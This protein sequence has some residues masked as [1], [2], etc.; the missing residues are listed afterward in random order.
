[1]FNEGGVIFIDRLAVL[2]RFTCLKSNIFYLFTL[3]I[4][5]QAT[6]QLKQAF[7]DP[8]VIP[9]LCEVMTGSTDPQV[10]SRPAVFFHNLSLALNP[11]C[12][13]SHL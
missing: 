5:F 11:P 13:Q 4:P 10:G 3:L 12:V 9:A 6:A 2:K 7:K 1:M 8:D